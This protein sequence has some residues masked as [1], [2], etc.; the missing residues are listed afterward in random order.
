MNKVSVLV[1]EDSPAD[2]AL[3][4]EYLGEVHGWNYEL[5][6]A[7]TVAEA[8]ALLA[9][10][11]TDVVLLDLSLPDSSGIET[12][13][14]VIGRHPRVA[15][16]VLTGMQDEQVALQAVRYGA[17]DYLEKKQL[18]PA[19]LHRSISYALERRKALREKENLLGDLALALERIEL[20]QGAL[21]VCSCCKKIHAE[22]DHWYQAE[23]YLKNRLLS[24]GGPAKNVC[25]ECL[26]HLHGEAG[27]G[28]DS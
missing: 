4:R 18:S 10:R 27:M 12:V 17:Q 21:P 2:V 14:T 23:E 8:L 15:V 26:R 3:V 16:V 28:L 7:G 9:R 1:V 25:P 6:V 24:S 11:A 22:D 5:E 13:R 19:M 20:L